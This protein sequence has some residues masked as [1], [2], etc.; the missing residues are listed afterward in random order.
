M[1][2]S[3]SRIYKGIEEVLA[4]EEERLTKAKFQNVDTENPNIEEVFNDNFKGV[5]LKEKYFI[6]EEI[7]LLKKLDRDN[8]NAAG[9][10]EQ[11]DKY[12]TFL[13]N[14]LNRKEPIEVKDKHNENWFVIGL[15]FATGEMD[16]L[17][18]QFDRN[19]T[20]IAKHLKPNTPEGK[21]PYKGIRPYISQSANN[22]T[23][24]DKNIFSRPNKIQEIQKY[25][26]DN[27]I[28]MTDHF[29]NLKQPV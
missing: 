28:E 2:S 21:E 4:K 10:R 27:N 17:L 9:E 16:V 19:Y 25:C 5:E 15:L 14:R 22:T 29:K 6:E 26:I 24:T 18:K 11:Y 12:F 1:E 8:L 3:R 20:Q 23:D 13:N 7:K